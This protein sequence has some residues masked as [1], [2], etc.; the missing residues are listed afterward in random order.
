MQVTAKPVDGTRMHVHFARGWCITQPAYFVQSTDY[1]HLYNCCL[2][3][4]RVKWKKSV[5]IVRICTESQSG[6]GSTLRTTV[7]HSPLFPCPSVSF[8]WRCCGCHCVA[9]AFKM[10][11]R[12]ELHP[13]DSEKWFCLWSC[14]MLDECQMG[15]ALLSLDGESRALSIHS[16]P[17]MFGYAGEVARSECLHSGI[18]CW[19]IRVSY[20]P[21]VVDYSR[22]S[23]GYSI[24]GV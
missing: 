1:K 4:L 23:S 5:V 14:C 19:S 16:R 10:R 6:S 8:H 13:G 18:C 15:T 22:L 17:I 9:L 7:T 11:W 12:R 3:S 24:A 21:L 20:L 2:M